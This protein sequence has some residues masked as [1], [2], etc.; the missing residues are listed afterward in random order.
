LGTT[1]FVNTLPSAGASAGDDNIP[2]VG[3]NRKLSGGPYMGPPFFLGG[4]MIEEHMIKKGRK[5]VPMPNDQVISDR[6]VTRN[7]GIIPASTVENEDELVMNKV[8][9]RALEP[10]SKQPMFPR[11]SWKEDQRYAWKPIIR[12]LTKNCGRPW[13]KVYSELNERGALFPMEAYSRGRNIVHWYVNDKNDERRSWWDFYVDKQ[14]IL[15]KTPPRPKYKNQESTQVAYKQSDDYWAVRYKGNW[16]GLYLGPVVKTSPSYKENL[17]D[18]YINYPKP[19]LK[20]WKELPW[21]LSSTLS[22]S[23]GKVQHI[24]EFKSLNKKE[25]KQLIT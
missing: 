10:S 12:F 6:V 8:R 25:I 1:T 9:A 5:R 22:G 23:G 18:L 16:F 19:I 11:S 24:E 7:M 2:D 17:P 3:S 15:R 4:R 21:K 13:N 20:L 14:G